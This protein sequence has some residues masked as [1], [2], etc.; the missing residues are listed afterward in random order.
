MLRFVLTKA[1]KADLKAIGRYTQATW[2]RD[3]RTRYLTL[4]DAGFRALA[5]NPLMGKNCDDIRPGYRKHQ[6]EGEKGRG[7]TRRRSVTGAA[8]QP[9]ELARVPLDQVVPTHRPA[10]AGPGRARGH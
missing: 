1:A 4:L 3:Q 9:P 5:D 2:G 7:G 6:I 8:P 10:P